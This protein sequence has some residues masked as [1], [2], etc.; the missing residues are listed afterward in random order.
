MKTLPDLGVLWRVIVAVLVTLTL[1]ELY[2]DHMRQ[3]EI[4]RQRIESKLHPEVQR[5]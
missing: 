4:E 1:V 5:K 3:F 2:A